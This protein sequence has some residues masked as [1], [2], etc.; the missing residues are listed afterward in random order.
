MV[1][2]AQDPAELFDVVRADGTP[3]GEVK[4][5]ALVHRDGDWHR[6]VHVWVAGIDQGDPFILL[7]RRSLEKDT[8]PGGLDVTVGG[9]YRSGE[10]LSEVLREIEEEI[11]VSPGVEEL[12]SLGVRIAAN[13]RTIGVLDRELQDV[14]LWRNDAPL[15]V[16]TPNPHE[17]L[18]LI[19]VPLEPLLNMLLGDLNAMQ[20]EC[21]SA[22]DRSLGRV[23]LRADDFVFTIDRYFY[24]AAIAV[25]RA[26]H[27]E[28]HVAI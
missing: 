22:A 6:A 20:V 25:S 14:F 18:E 5:R 1:N 15:T 16:Y 26:L 19:K 11:G 7:Q 9:H 21:L 8:W 13:E 24:R 12:R 27:G 17:L 3:T 23:R 10:G 4:Q 28:R 2:A